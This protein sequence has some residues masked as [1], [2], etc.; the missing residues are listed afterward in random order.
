MFTVG[1]APR[2]H[3]TWIHIFLS[4]STRAFHVGHVPWSCA[5]RI[6]ICLPGRVIARFVFSFVA[7]GGSFS[8]DVNLGA[9]QALESEGIWRAPARSSGN[10]RALRATSLPAA[11]R[12]RL[13]VIGQQRAVGVR[14]VDRVAKVS[15]PGGKSREVTHFKPTEYR[16][17]RELGADIAAFGAGLTAV[18]GLQPGDRLGIYADTCCE[19]LV[20][21]HGAWARGAVVATVYANLGDDAVAQ[22]IDEAAIRVLVCGGKAIAGVVAACGRAGVRCPEFVALDVADEAVATAAT[23]APVHAW[24]K[25]L[26]HGRAN[27]LPTAENMADDLALIMY[28]SGTTGRAK[29]VEI[30]HGNLLAAVLSLGT[31][32]EQFLPAT[33]DESYTAFLPLAHILELVAENIMLLRGSLIGYGTPRTLTEAEPCGDFVEFKPVL[34]IAVP[35]VFETVKKNIEAK[36]GG[37]WLLQQGLFYSTLRA[38]RLARLR[39]Q[40]EPYLAP[41]VF[42]GARAIV[43]GRVKAIVSGGGPLSDETQT[44]LSA[45]MG[46]AVG[47]GYALTETCAAVSV[48][49]LSDTA[50]GN[51]GALLP[52]VELRLVPVDGFAQPRV[53]EI[54][55]RGPMVA[56]G[57]HRQPEKTAESFLPGGWFAT[58]DIGCMRADGSLQLV[59]RLKALVKN[60]LG[61][62]IALEFLEAMYALCSLALPNGVCVVVDPQRAYICAIVVTDERKANAFAASHGITAP[63]PALLELPA[64]VKKAGEA[65]ADVAKQGGRKPFEVVKH[66]RVFADEWTPENG[67][68]TAAMKLKR[69]AIEH[70]YAD[71][72]AGMFSAES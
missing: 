45:V 14:P 28:T 49:G 66:V 3:E 1:A 23:G 70:R 12:E 40:A 35:R 68:L 31:T 58:G 19:W 69:A 18:V 46:C 39:S 38:A 33:P 4:Q 20:S 62:Y 54:Q 7:M 42:A 56:R 15:V 57:Y 59:G 30:T 51:V 8:R 47:Q 43:G 16:T 2:T 60:V 50:V 52:G 63:W 26:Q 41:S 13:P 32:L 61:E 37:A 24:A 71:A 55:V 21:C 67:S 25:I 36:V 27:A 44:F 5:T 9:V 10:G 65:M 11:L 29:G 22:A 48:Q 53:G 64:F 6:A 34:L 17:Y 72:I